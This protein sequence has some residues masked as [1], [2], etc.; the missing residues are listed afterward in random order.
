MCK[1]LNDSHGWF[2]SF[3][4][5]VEAP[6]GDNWGQPLHVTVLGSSVQQY[7][8]Q[9]RHSRDLTTDSYVTYYA[10]IVVYCWWA[11][12]NS[13]SESWADRTLEATSIDMFCAPP[14]IVA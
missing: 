11:A 2:F 1:A 14:L 10:E 3:L 4:L 12:L 8:F 13:P 9:A 6:L 7:E 5:E